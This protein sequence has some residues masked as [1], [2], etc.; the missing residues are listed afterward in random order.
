MKSVFLIF[1]FFI[2][3]WGV[4][5]SSNS[6]TTTL[7]EKPLTEAVYASGYNRGVSEIKILS[8]T[9]GIISKRTFR[10]GDSIRAGE[11]LYL[12]DYRPAQARKAA[13]ETTLRISRENLSDNSPAYREAEAL[14]KTLGSKVAFDSSL[15][16]RYQALFKQEAVAKIE[17]EKMRLQYEAS[18][19]E[20]EM[21]ENRVS[22]LKNRLEQEWMQA[23]SA[24]ALADFDESVYKILS[25]SSGKILKLAKEPGELVRRGEEVA[26]VSND[27]GHILKLSIDEQDISR[28]IPGQK[29][30]VKL[31]AWPEQIWE[32]Q[33]YKI[34]PVV[35]TR[36]QSVQVD[37]VWTKAP[38]G[39]LS[40]M[41]AEANIVLQE[42]SKTFVLPRSAVRQDSVKVW[43]DG[44]AIAK[45]V[46]TGMVSLEEVEILSGLRPDEEVLRYQE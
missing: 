21:Q 45:A 26:L 35:N 1:L 4:S 12:L 44:K 42:K 33:V 38:E 40:G 9:E 3:V 18:R 2:L 25:P 32:A 14:L 41:A 30:L 46:Q 15:Y 7:V 31:D 13:A 23:R 28:V 20:Y 37:A 27:A 24:E 16:F 29:V 39:L 43:K 10:E 11:I 8:Q 6:E 17:V 5:C 36:E 22:Q 19:N 34:Y